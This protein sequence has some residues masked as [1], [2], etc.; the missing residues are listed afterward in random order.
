MRSAYHKADLTV[1]I[2]TTAGERAS[3]PRG[4]DQLTN[5]ATLAT[6]TKD[7]VLVRRFLEGIAPSVRG[8][9]R[10]VLG[11][12]HVEL[13]DIVQ[14]CLIKILRALPS[15]RFEG[16]IVHYTNRIALR[17]AIAGRQRGRNREQ[18]DRALVEQGTGNSTSGQD[19]LP[20]LWFLRTLIDELPTVQAEVVVM[21]MVLGYSVEEIAVATGVSVNT[22]KSRL[23]VAK[24]HLRQRLGGEA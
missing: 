14:E 17:A 10:A 23:R 15:Y 11:P 5:L 6:R 20:G 1:E 22:A 3:D 13:E 2:G 7:P 18:R 8:V 9:C 4:D 21:R 12:R 24:E 16:S 19:S